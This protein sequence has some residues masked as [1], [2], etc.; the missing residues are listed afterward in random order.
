FN[1]PKIIPRFPF[2]KLKDI[3]FYCYDLFEINPIPT[4][5]ATAFPDGTT[6]LLCALSV[7]KHTA[8]AA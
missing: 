6:R 1:A 8:N 7:F 2:N 5:R 4:C 3:I